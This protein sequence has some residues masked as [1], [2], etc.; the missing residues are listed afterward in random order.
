MIFVGPMLA[1]IE[2]AAGWLVL[3]FG[4]P[5]AI[6]YLCVSAKEKVRT[7]KMVAVHGILQFFFVADK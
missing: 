4:A 3:A 6:A 1:F 5:Y 7:K 2:A